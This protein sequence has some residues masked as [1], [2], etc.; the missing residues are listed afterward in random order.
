VVIASKT[1]LL[2]PMPS[3][4]AK[5]G[6]SGGVVDLR[7][8]MGW[9]VILQCSIISPWSLRARGAVESLKRVTMSRS[10]FKFLGPS[11]SIVLKPTSNIVALI[12]SRVKL[13]WFSYFSHSIKRI[14][15]AEK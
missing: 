13:I 9:T 2:L 3:K 14:Y 11:I 10:P 7:L 15:F 4:R 5:V 12:L 8:P 6:Q 1:P